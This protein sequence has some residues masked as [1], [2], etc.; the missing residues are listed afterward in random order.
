MDDQDLIAAF[1]TALGEGAISI[2]RLSGK[3][4]VEL[5][6]SIFRPRKSGLDLLMVPS[7]TM[8]LGDICNDQ[9][10]IL[11][12]V[13]LCAMREPRTYTREDVVEIFCHG[14]VLQVRRVLD[15]VLLKGARL[16]EPGE[17]TKRSFL[18]GRI[19]LAQA[20]A[21]LDLI[22]A[23]SSK[24]ADLACRQLTGKASSGINEMRGD[25]KKMLAEI[26][27]EIDFPEE[28]DPMPK[29]VREGKLAGLQEKVDR[30]L[31]G[32]AAGRVY[33]EGLTTV[34]LGKPNVGKSTLLN[35]LLGEE[36]ALVT[37]IPGTTR[38]LIEEML[39]IEGIPLRIIDTAGIRDNAGL[40][41]SLGIA[42]AKEALDQADLVLA[43]FDVTSGITDEDIIVLNLLHGK[44]GIILLNK[45]DT[46]ETKIDVETI[47]KYADQNLPV[48]EISARLGWRQ[49]ELAESILQVV[50]AG[51]IT[52]ESV[53]LTRK[54]HQIAMEK[55][56]ERL[57]TAMLGIIGELPLECIAIDLWDAWSALGEILGD[58]VPEE[59]INSIFEEFCI[60]K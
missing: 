50:G 19:D 40:V 27:A 33:R 18:N 35:M 15:L 14:G 38:D 13:L 30:Y 54:R 55:V 7:H 5:A 47:K 8:I 53:V 43:L 32:A 20:E 3:G 46:G 28:V 11:D 45:I 51:Q 26:E 42:R 58:A 23:H 2:V 59:V 25:L 9:G 29:E 56:Q 4:A 39:V 31:A 6:A 48:I 60:G 41:E 57:R 1:G 44:K 21:V 24:G 12:E 34:L 49:K 36:R 16:A 17:F 10:E 52:E 22:R 37:E